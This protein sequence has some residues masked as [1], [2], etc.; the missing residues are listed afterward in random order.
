RW[1]RSVTNAD[2]GRRPVDLSIS[3]T[4]FNGSPAKS[5]R[6]SRI[7]PARRP[8]AEEQAPL[9]QSALA[10]SRRGGR[11]RS[12]HSASLAGY[13]GGQVIN[14]GE[15]HLENRRGVCLA[16]THGQIDR[17]RSALQRTADPR[18]RQQILRM[19]GHKRQPAGGRN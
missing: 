19:G 9:P 16:V 5:P 8:V 11:S 12:T 1:T 14:S 6:A 3:M 13:S 15:E 10:S 2:W 4:T 7:Q 17:W 18:P